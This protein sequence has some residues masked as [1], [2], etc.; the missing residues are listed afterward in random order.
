MENKNIDEL[1]KNGVIK[2][3][4]FLDTYNLKKFKNFILKEKPRKGSSKN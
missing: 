3:P 4:N 2:I 1:R